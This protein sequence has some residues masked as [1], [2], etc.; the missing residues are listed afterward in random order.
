MKEF[1]DERFSQEVYVYGE[2]PNVWYAEQIKNMPVGKKALFPAEGEGRNCV[3]AAQLGWEVTAVDI[4]EEGRK[5]ALQLAQKKSV[6]IDY[7]LESVANR[8]FGENQFDLI[9]LI[10]AHFPPAFRTKVHQQF[11]HTLRPG[12]ILLMEGFH[13]ENLPYKLAN[14]SIGGPGE[15]SLLYDEELLL[16]DFK[17]LH[18][19]HL[20]KEEAELKEGEFHKGKGMVIHLIAKKI[21]N[22]D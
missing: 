4:S 2:E 12:G 11:V 9:V 6:T 15:E 20:E 14:P 18:I 7:Q 8:D 19:E 1:W 13:K 22:I 17:D 21:S 3:Y 10:F 16:E 5:K